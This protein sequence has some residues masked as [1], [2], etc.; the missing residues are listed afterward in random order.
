MM[1]STIQ[2]LLQIAREKMS[3]ARYTPEQREQTLRLLN[4][5]LE[6]AAEDE[7]SE[8]NARATAKLLSN[9]T[10]HHNLFALIQQ[11]AAE[12][13]ALKRISVNLA[14]SLQ[15][16]AVL[17]RVA[18]EA[19]RLIKNPQSVHIFLYEQGVLRFGAAL[20]AEG[21]RNR[22][23]SLP[24]PD[25]L[26]YTVART[27]QTIFIEEMRGHPLFKTAPQEWEG[28]II[29]IPLKSDE[30][31]VGVMN[32]SLRPGRTF[33]P[34]ELRLLDLLATQAAVAIVNARL[35][36]AMSK[37]AMSDMLTGLPNRRALDARL[38]NEVQRAARYG[39][40]FA[41]LM[42]DLDGFKAINDTYGHDVGDRV[43]RDF[44]RFLVESKRSSDF[45]AR[46][47]GDEMTML[48]PE[49]DGNSALQ[50]AESITKRMAQFQPLLPD[51]TQARLGIS[52]G[53]AI[54][55]NHAHTASDLLRAADEA[56]YRAKRH[57]R[58]SFL[59]ARGVTGELP[60]ELST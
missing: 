33:S 58:G 31:V 38:E 3:G 56:L 22:I 48:L 36:Q 5:L 53:I 15:L 51:G 41:V 44:A 6:L 45:L 37:E 9:V 7:K 54:Y 35:H 16:Q 19:M 34:A 14:S 24:R 29:G 40:P 26:T 23:L 20:D 60:S 11:Q 18:T 30:M 32:M 13:E 27:K 55:P 21:N 50:L 17:D 8:E 25:G 57:A 2:A 52:G 1:N 42:M 4:L 49:T 47:G 39:H 12:L 43:L 46:Y 28:A 59:V 10:R